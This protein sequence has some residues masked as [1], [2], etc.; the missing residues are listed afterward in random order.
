MIT[1]NIIQRILLIKFWQWTGT[2]FTIEVNWEQYIISAKHVFPNIIKW[3]SIEI[4]HDNQWKNIDITP[5]FCE[6]ENVDIIALKIN[7]QNITPCHEIKLWLWG[8]IYWQDIYFLWFPYWIKFENEI[9]NW[10]PFPLVKKWILSWMPGWKDSPIYMDGH[11][12][13]WF[14]WWPIIF[15]SWELLSIWWVIS[16]YIPDNINEWENSWIF[17]WYKLNSIIDAIKK[18]PNC[19]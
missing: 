8:I 17:V 13:R 14:S 2:W 18:N 7:T 10:Y 15:K 19:N 1:T 4:F 16:W 3:D 5:I 6:N 9:N 12:N 11:N